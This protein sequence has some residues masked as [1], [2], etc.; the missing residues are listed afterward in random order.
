MFPPLLLEKGTTCTPEGC[1]S[2]ELW[3]K[4]FTFWHHE[5]LRRVHLRGW[6]GNEARDW[7]E[8]YIGEGIG[9]TAASMKETTQSCCLPRKDI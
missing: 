8:R 4:L 3:F 5:M 7:G 1:R 2:L 6:L 9:E